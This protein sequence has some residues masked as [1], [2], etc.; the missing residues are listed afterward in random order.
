MH[1][2][3]Q[4]ILD[5]IR[6]DIT[7]AKFFSI[8]ADE[9]QDISTKAQLSIC[10]RF[11]GENLEVNEAFLVLVELSR[12][13]ANSGE[14]NDG[15]STMSGEVSGVQKRIKTIYPPAWYNVH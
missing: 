7:K 2:C 6:R 12:T 15:C 10:I 9:T 3:A 5:I 1:Y 14:G 11:V 13:D 4:E 8:L